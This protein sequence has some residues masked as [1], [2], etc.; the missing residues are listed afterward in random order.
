MALGEFNKGEREYSMQ[1]YPNYSSN[2][3]LAWVSW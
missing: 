3:G 2:L 1:A